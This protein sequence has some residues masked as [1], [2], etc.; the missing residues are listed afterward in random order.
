MM[1]LYLAFS[2]DCRGGGPE[3]EVV[4]ARRCG[5]EYGTSECTV[6]VA[7]RVQVEKRCTART[8]RRN[9]HPSLV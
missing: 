1:M 6:E 8:S 7:G 3:L 5:S 2:S 4:D 9:R